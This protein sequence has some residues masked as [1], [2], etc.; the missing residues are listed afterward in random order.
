[1]Y[2]LFYLTML[3]TDTVNVLLVSENWHWCKTIILTENQ[4]NAKSNIYQ[5]K[6]GGTVATY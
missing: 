2:Y 1:M 6:K 5:P 4:F 3:K